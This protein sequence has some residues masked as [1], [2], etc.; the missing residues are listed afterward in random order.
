[1]NKE[2][3]R[4]NVLELIITYKHNE[5]IKL[6]ED[7]IKDLVLDPVHVAGYIFGL[8]GVQKYL[9]AEEVFYKYKSHITNDIAC[10]TF[11]LCTLFRLQKY[12]EVKR[13]YEQEVIF[14]EKKSSEAISYYIH[15]LL[16]LGKLS[17]AEDVFNKNESTIKDDLLALSTYLT[18]LFN[19]SRY[20]E[21]VQFFNKYKDILI[22]HPLCISMYVVSLVS[23]EEYSEAVSAFEKYVL[24][25]NNVPIAIGHYMIALIHLRKFA[26]AR[27]TFE[28][29]EL[30]VGN[31]IACIGNYMYAL[32][33]MKTQKSYNK[34]IEIYEKNKDI[35]EKSEDGVNCFK[36]YVRAREKTGQD[37]VY[38]D[39]NEE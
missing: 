16:G 11:H 31:S 10:M 27:D 33:E 26:K 2:L 17:K 7:N 22:K 5:L 20:S 4:D 1:M 35:I 36:A 23:V 9:E 32:N 21:A 8:N 25:L 30:V 28:K 15:S 18:L 14:V 39:E 13:M 12:Q 29:Y 34:I 6:C 38:R 3:S 19:S 37:I 24:N